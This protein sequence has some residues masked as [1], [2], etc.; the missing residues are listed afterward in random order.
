MDKDI[1][2]AIDRIRIRSKNVKAEM[3]LRMVAETSIPLIGLIGTIRDKLDKDT[4]RAIARQTCQAILF[5][6]NDNIDSVLSE[7]GEMRKITIEMDKEV[8]KEDIL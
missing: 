6:F 1:I 3:L 2:D 5:H 8:S 7:I 4:A